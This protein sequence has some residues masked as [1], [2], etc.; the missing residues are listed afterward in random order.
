MFGV[1][2]LAEQKISCLCFKDYSY[3]GCCVGFGLGLLLKIYKY[4]I[5]MWDQ[6]LDLTAS[7]VNGYHRIMKLKS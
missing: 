6:N 1:C 7:W 5:K 3:E 2:V 4:S